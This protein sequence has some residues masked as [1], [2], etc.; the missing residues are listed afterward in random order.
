MKSELKKKYFQDPGSKGLPSSYPVPPEDPDLLFFIQRNQNFDTIVYKLNRAPGGLI[1][2]DLPIHAYWIKYSEG[3][4]QR[5][6]NYMQSKLAYGYESSEVSPD[7]YKFHFVSYPQLVFYIARR[8]EER[9]HV[10]T[11]INGRQARLSNIYVYAVEFGVF[12]DV[13][14]IELYGEDLENG[15]FAYQKITTE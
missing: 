2:R 1:N 12:P 5:D 15:L 11:Y 3:G 8:D 7:L 4:V 9:F 13:K 14:F 6:L 10:V